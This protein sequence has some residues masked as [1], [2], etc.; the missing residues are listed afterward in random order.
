MSNSFKDYLY[1]QLLEEGYISEED[2]E[3]AESLDKEDLLQSTDLEE[4]DIKNYEIEF[5]SYCE[6]HGLEPEWDLN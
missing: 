6:E 2:W 5:E 4:A 1:D 3:D